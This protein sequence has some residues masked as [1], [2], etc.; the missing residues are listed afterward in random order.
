MATYNLQQF[1]TLT[2]FGEPVFPAK[3]VTEAQ[4]EDAAVRLGADTVYVAVTPSAD[5][6]F[7]V[8][9]S[10]VAAPSTSM[11]V[12]AG[13]TR[14]FNVSPGAQPYLIGNAA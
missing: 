14:G 9:G 5:M 2:G 10:G 1:A 7:N 8:G 11:K 12:L 6:Y 3:T 4:A 13:D